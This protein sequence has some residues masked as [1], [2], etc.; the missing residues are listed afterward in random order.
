MAR[1]ALESLS[2]AEKLQ[3]AIKYVETCKRNV[4]TEPTRTKKERFEQTLIFIWAN[5]VIADAER[6]KRRLDA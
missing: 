4:K 6:E 1:V 2:K 5:K 3:R